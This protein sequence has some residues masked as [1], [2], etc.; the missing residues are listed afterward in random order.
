MKISLTGSHGLVARHLIPALEDRGHHVLRVVR[1]D[2]S[3][4]EVRWDPDAGTIDPGALEVDAVIHLAG[5]GVASRRWNAAHRQA[6]MDSRVKGT[7]VL[8]GRIAEASSRPSVLLSASAIGYYGDRGDQ[9]LTESAGPGTGFLVDVARNWEA[10]TAKAEEA[11]V[12]TVHLRT[13]IVQAAE[14]GALKPQLLVFKAGLGAPLGSGQQWVSWISIDDEVGAI[15]HALGNDSIS[16]PLNLASPN[17]VRNASY[18]ATLAK[19]LHR[20]AVLKVPA[21]A[22]R[23]ALGHQMA[24]E[25]LLAS[26]RVIPAELAATGYHW[27]QPE[28][29]GALAALLH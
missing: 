4:G 13:G 2:A 22:L 8:A 15:L 10:A 9:E 29:A 7:S 6:V 28:L 11:G 14:G 16:G 3:P 24:D 12:R 21:A 19:A 26:Q 1:G 18:T 27:R 25:M 5:V 20:P 17:P 23:L